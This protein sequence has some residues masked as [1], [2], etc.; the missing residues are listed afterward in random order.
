[1]R[2]ISAR[3]C[4]ASPARH[5]A[6]AGRLRRQHELEPAACADL[7]LEPNRPAERVRELAR[8]REAEPGPPAVER[9]ER[10]EDA[11]PLLRRDPGAGVLHP[12]LDLAVDRRA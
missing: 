10:P 3:D 11:L 12:Q 1:V 7:G 5:A 4:A 6:P 2:S 8:D 9:P